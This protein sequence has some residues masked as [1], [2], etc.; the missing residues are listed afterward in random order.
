LNSL[1]F[2]AGPG[3]YARFGFWTGTCLDVSRAGPDLFWRA[4]LAAEDDH[5]PIIDLYELL[6]R[7]KGRKEI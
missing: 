1:L 3:K 6:Q 2:L 5:I 7:R 4:R